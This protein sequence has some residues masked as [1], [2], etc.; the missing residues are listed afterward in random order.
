MIATVPT[1]LV[2]AACSEEIVAV[3]G[4]DWLRA[5]DALKL[6]CLVGIGKA[7]GFFAGPVLFAASRARFRAAMLW[8]VASISV[9]GVVGAGILLADAEL[10]E[11]VVGMAGTRAILFVPVLIPIN[12][13]IIAWVT[14]F[15]VRRFLPRAAAPVLAGC[16]GLAAEWALH[17]G[18]LVDELPALPRLVAVGTTAVVAAAAVLLALEPLAR[19]YA[20]ALVRRLRAPAP[21][22]SFAGG[23]S[24]R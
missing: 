11:Q 4:D 23:T 1:L 10:E 17:A 6:L 18:G 12:L 7:I 8:G 3:L 16:A 22:P 14:G 13:A 15:S 2:V 9:L 24:E 19:S 20:R 21:A 5:G